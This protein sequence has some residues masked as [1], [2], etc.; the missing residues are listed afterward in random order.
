M[1]D[2][3]LVSIIM[4]SFCCDKFIAQA[5]YSVLEQTYTN[6]ELIVVDDGSTD[7]TQDI[8]ASFTAK[9]TRIRMFI[10]DKNSG[11]AI[12][13]N[14][15]L[16]ES[17]GRW[18]AFLDSDDL[19]LPE[20]LEKQLAFMVTHGCGFTYHEYT[21][22]DEE[23]NDLGVYVSGKSHVGVFDMYACCWPGCLTV[24]YDAEKVGLIQINNIGRN[25]DTAMWLKAIHK[26]DCHLLQ[27]NLAKYRRRK[28][29]VTPKSLPQKIWAHYPLFS[30]AEEMNPILA[31]FWV[32]VNIFGNAYKKLFY[33]KR[34]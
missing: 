23:G 13:R 31:T 28:V 34:T 4:P 15:A 7:S 14:R 22:I 6:W 17:K 1:I 33:I 10:N 2:Y 25:N 19:W 11:P 21:E 26:A 32:I 29:S 27:E 16:R 12:S 24:M 9:D 8:V 18:I 5:I 20:K 30:T 3:G